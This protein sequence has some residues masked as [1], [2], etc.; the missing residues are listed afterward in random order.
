MEFNVQELIGYAASAL[1]VAR[2]TGDEIEA[3]ETAV[4]VF[5]EL[6][7]SAQHARRRA[8]HLD[9]RFLA[10]RRQL[11]HRV[12][13]RDLE[14]ADVGHVEHLADFL[15][16]RPRFGAQRRSCGVIQIDAFMGFVG[17]NENDS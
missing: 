13:R 5:D 4:A 15:H 9:V 17:L 11:E 6:V 16:R 1:V 2:V 7:R 3:E 12:E 10:D 8:A 14:D